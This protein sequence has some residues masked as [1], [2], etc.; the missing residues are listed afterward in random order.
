MK[1]LTLG[2]TFLTC[3]IYSY[4]AYGQLTRVALISVYANRS[5]S[6][7]PLD[8]IINEKIMNDSS[9]DLT[10]KVEDFANLINTQFLTL[11]PFPFIPKEEVLNAPGYKD[12]SKKT[13]RMNDSVFSIEGKVTP[14][15]PASGY[16]A[17]ASFGILDDVD[18]IKAS[19]DLLPPDVDGVMIAYLSFQLEE[20]AGAMG[21]TIKRVRA[22]ANIKIFNRKG[23]RIFKLKESEFSKG[24]VAG[25]RGFIV[26]PNKVIPLVNDAADRLFEE[27]KKRL[28][29]SLAKLAK[30]IQKDKED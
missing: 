22:Y 20:Q 18:A 10:P 29:K 6:D 12:L 3:F 2:L 7:N 4:S 1:R 19:F 16:I 9:F 17:I 11:F 5:L 14:Y 24:N 26:E 21:M 23:Q 25:F 8:K 15:I 27:L 28:P 30:Q 13:S